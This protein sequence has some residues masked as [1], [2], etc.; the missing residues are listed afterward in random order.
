[1]NSY[2]DGFVFYT[3]KAVKR[4]LGLSS[5]ELLK[6]VWGKP[7]RAVA[8]SPT[9]VNAA[10]FCLS[11]RTVSTVRNGRSANKLYRECE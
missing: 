1:M 6:E 10:L 5:V 7:D 2:A 8:V 11:V 3:D 9:F 4:K